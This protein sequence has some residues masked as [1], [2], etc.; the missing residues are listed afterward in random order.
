M[1]Q[2]RNP[3]DVVRVDLLRPEGRRGTQDVVLQQDGRRGPGRDGEHPRA[4]HWQEG[5]GRRKGVHRWEKLILN[6]V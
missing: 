5:R 6:Q 2:P 4:V 3:Q 1:F